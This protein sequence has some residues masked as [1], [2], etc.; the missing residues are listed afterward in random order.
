MSGYMYAD[1]EAAR[2]AE[3]AAFDVVK[4]AAAK[5][6]LER[7]NTLSGARSRTRCSSGPK[8]P[9]KAAEEGRMRRQRR[10]MEQQEAAVAQQAAKQAVAA[11]A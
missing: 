8:A 1:L 3:D 6:N 10:E 5:K 4:A 7:L 9:T 2:H 11:R